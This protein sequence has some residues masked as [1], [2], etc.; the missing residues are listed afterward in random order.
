MKDKYE[1][2]IAYKITYRRGNVIG[3]GFAPPRY[4]DT[5][6]QRRREGCERE[7]PCQVISFDTYKTQR[8]SNNVYAKAT[9]LEEAL[10]QTPLEQRRT[11]KGRDVQKFRKGLLGKFFTSS[12]SNNESNIIDLSRIGNR[13][14]R[15]YALQNEINNAREL[16]MFEGFFNRREILDYLTRQL[17]EHYGFDLE[18]LQYL[19]TSELLYLGLN[20]QHY[21]GSLETRIEGGIH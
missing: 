17:S 13:I 15:E 4:E 2:R 9:T 7:E 1:N 12:S 21:T 5:D 10:Q 16:G 20:S 6:F 19:N 14:Q 3:L 18:P 11:R 8:T